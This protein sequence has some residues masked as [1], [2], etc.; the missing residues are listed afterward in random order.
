MVCVNYSD[1]LSIT[2]PINKNY[3]DNIIV[4]TTKEDLKT[5][6]MCSSNNVKYVITNRLYENGD[7]FNKGKAINDGAKALNKKDWVIITDSDIIMNKNLKETLTKTNLDTESIYGTSRYMCPSN[8]EWSKYL[9]DE[10]ITNN[11]EHQHGRLTIGVG[12]FQLFNC[13]SKIIKEKNGIFYAEK[14]SH[15][16]RSDRFFLRSWEDNKRQKLNSPVIHLGSD[17]MG[18]N[19]N[20]RTTSNWFT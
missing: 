8:E 12:F 7:K 10:S 18:A 1:F 16:G 13:N 6:K 4:V 19:W 20:G 2:L 5:Q 15:A 17:K 9:N 3:F 14:F 11:W